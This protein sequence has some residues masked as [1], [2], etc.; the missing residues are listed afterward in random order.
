MSQTPSVEIEEVGKVEPIRIVDGLEV[1]DG[2][3]GVDVK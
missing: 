3:D 1:N 2:L